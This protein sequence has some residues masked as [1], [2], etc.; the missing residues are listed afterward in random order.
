MDKT[1]K[2]ITF[3]NLPQAVA[4]LCNL[5][6][7]FRH[8]REFFNIKPQLAMEILRDEA[9]VLDD[10]EITLYENNQ[11]IVPKPGKPDLPTSPLLCII[12]LASSSV[13]LISPSTRKHRRIRL[14]HLPREL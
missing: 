13:W 8:N 7:R 5:N 10:A 2:T 14:S 1:E 6:L 9:M 3:D 4:T 12:D 11:P